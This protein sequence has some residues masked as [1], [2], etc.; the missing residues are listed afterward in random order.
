M[1]THSTRIPRTEGHAVHGETR[2]ESSLYNSH[3]T[4]DGSCSTPCWRSLGDGLSPSHTTP[5]RPI[6]H[7]SR[8]RQSID[9]SVHSAID[10]HDTSYRQ[11]S[12]I[13]PSQYS[14]F[15]SKNTIILV[16][17]LCACTHKKLKW[18]GHN[19]KSNSFLPRNPSLLLESVFPCLSPKQYGMHACQAHA[20]CSLNSC[21]TLF[22]MT[23]PWQ[24]VSLSLWEAGGN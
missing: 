23:I 12:E 8:A 19:G 5:P 24:L 13:C 17:L 6:E 10:L 20:T 1:N 9:G 7:V 14:A 18:F 11:S 3:V 16:A 4:G 2:Q 22:A 21:Q 15:N